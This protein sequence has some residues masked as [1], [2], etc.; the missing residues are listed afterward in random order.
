MKRGSFSSGEFSRPKTLAYLKHQ[1]R[2]S[3]LS[4]WSVIHY[5]WLCPALTACQPSLREKDKKGLDCAHHV[6]L[7]PFRTRSSWAYEKK[8]PGCCT[9]RFVFHNDQQTT[10][11][12]TMKLMKWN[13]EPTSQRSKSIGFIHQ[14]LELP[15][16]F[17]VSRYPHLGFVSSFPFRLVPF[18]V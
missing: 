10:R 9:W 12:S 15:V 8:Q 7:P 17:V 14:N 2:A 1:E 18:S 3:S 13:A 5:E 16:L 11:Q 6:F 4:N